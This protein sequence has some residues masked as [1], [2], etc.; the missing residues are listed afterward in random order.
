[1][2]NGIGPITFSALRLIVSSVLMLLLRPLFSINFNFGIR[3]SRN[4]DEVELFDNNT[5]G[6]VN[7]PRS[8]RL[9]RL[10]SDDRPM[11]VAASLDHHHYQQTRARR[12]KSL[13]LTHVNTVVS[14]TGRFIPTFEGLKRSDS[15]S[16][17]TNGPIHLPRPAAF[18]FKLY[19]LG[20]LLGV[21]DAIAAILQQISMVVITGGQS[22]FITSLYVVAVPTIEYLFPNLGG[23]MT[24]ITWIAAFL[25]VVGVYLLSGCTEDACF[26]G[27]RAF[28]VG[29]AVAGMF[30]WSA[31]IIIAGKATKLVDCLDF[32]FIS[33][34]V[35]AIF[36]LTAAFIFEANHLVYPYESIT[37]NWVNILAV[38]F[39]EAFAC[40]LCNIGQ[41]YVHDS[42]AALIMSFESVLAAFA[43]YVSIGET[44]TP[45]E[46]SGC[47]V[48]LL[49]ILLT[50]F[51]TTPSSLT[52]LSTAND[53]FQETSQTTDIE[54]ASRA[55]CV[56][57]EQ[58]I[59]RIVQSPS[60][61]R[62]DD[63]SVKVLGENV[64]VLVTAPKSPN[65][66]ALDNSS[67]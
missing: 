21:N 46:V 58:G 40:T 7:S 57:E 20:S 19:F 64:Y 33:F 24:I 36:S 26:T 53:S 49:S 22:A 35:S 50:I 66:A 29:T 54:F 10:R 48:I 67:S 11:P 17:E 61:F 34:L 59:K 12:S 2:L 41:K 43:C 37:K 30:F 45:S 60:L 9:V 14:E 3:S 25:S 31:S 28:G 65:K 5:Y 13:D 8:P 16:P 47:V 38:G 42:R 15:F 32:T 63:V 56:S 4:D 55:S 27:A 52:S 39:T 18:D 62:L 1:M 23:H 44:L 51:E 6:S